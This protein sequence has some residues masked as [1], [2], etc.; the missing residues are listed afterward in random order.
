M[1]WVLDNIQLIFIVAG[2]IAY[3]LVQ[4]RRRQ[5]VRKEAEAE[6]GRVPT[7]EEM[8]ERTRRI[9]EEIRRKIAERQEGRPPTEEQIENETMFPTPAVVRRVQVAA[10]PPLPPVVVSIETAPGADAM[11][12]ALEE[13]RRISEQYQKLEVRQQAVTVA[14]AAAGGTSNGVTAAAFAIAPHAAVAAGQR[15]TRL[16]DD[17]SDRD[18]LRRA[19]VLREIL[20][21][22][23]GL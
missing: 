1:R 2:A 5:E 6:L 8:A 15:R 20:G 18:S 11:R 19:I 16:I 10:P 4:T 7:A 22:A 9:Q 21:P 13:Q 14:V 12:R 23:K 17:L 3:W